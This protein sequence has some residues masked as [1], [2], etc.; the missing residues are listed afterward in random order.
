MNITNFAYIVE[1]SKN[2]DDAVVA[3]LKS[4]E[5]KGWALFQVYDIKERLAAKGFAHQSLK[6]IEICNAKH[7]NNFISKNKLVSLCMPCK[8][9][10]IQD[11][12]KVKIVGMLPNMLVEMFPEVTMQ[13]ALEVEKDIKEIVDNSK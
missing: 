6:I 12:N 9:N 5:K 4:I 11:G 3:V 7:A 2:F 1:T 10:V 13:E 8:I